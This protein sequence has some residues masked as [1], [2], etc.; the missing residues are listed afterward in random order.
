MTSIVAREYW[1]KKGEAS[2]YVYRKFAEG[3]PKGAA[4]VLFLI[5]GSSLSAVPSYD[6]KIP[7][8]DD[9]SVM[10]YFV[11][12]GFDVWTMDHDGYGRSSRT[13]SNGDIAA[14]ID[15][16]DVAMP[17]VEEES[18]RAKAT[19]FGQSGGA[20]RAAAYAEQRPERVERLVLDGFVWTGKGSPTLE[21]RRER[22]DEWRASNT[23][24]FDRAFFETI[25]NRDHPGFGDPRVASFWADYETALGDTFPTGTYLDMSANLP[26][27]DPTK[28]QCP[29]LI[30]RGEFDG[31][32]TDDDLIEFFRLLPNKDKHF[33]LMAG[34]AHV[35][36]QAI[37]RHRFLHVMKA[38]L[39]LPPRRDPLASMS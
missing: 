33:S 13:S 18:G 35:G 16:L 23:R 39:T 2:L 10:D 22:L 20:V 19:V 9:Y 4:P 6:L 5:H 12:L 30:I 26:K 8:E 37:N 29:V 24:K 27:A 36:P 34:Q 32:A 17:L 1:V 7:G 3:T 11:R 21:K 25:F 28:I 15:D 14:A 31:I 38:F